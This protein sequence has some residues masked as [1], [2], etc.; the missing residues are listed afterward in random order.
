MELMSFQ[1]PDKNALDAYKHD[2][3]RPKLRLS[4]FLFLDLLGTTARDAADPAPLLKAMTDA[5]FWGNS[6]QSTPAAVARWFSDNLGLAYPIGDEQHPNIQ[7]ADSAMS[8]I[9]FSACMHQVA[10]FDHGFSSRGGISV[11]LF[12]ADEAMIYGPAL[13]RAVQLEKERAKYPRI[14]LDEAAVRVAKESLKKKIEPRQWARAYLMV[15]ADGVVFVNWLASVHS[16]PDETA[17]KLGEYRDQIAAL[18]AEHDGCTVVHDKY[19]W[20]AA[21]F[22]WFIKEHPGLDEDQRKTLLVD[23]ARPWPSKF[24]AFGKDIPAPKDG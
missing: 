16:H 13:N 3:D 20:L 4:A 14:V 23:Q 11:D 5:R 18:L 8:D 10:L 12:Y 21:Y 19:R 9:I 2:D 1:P 6:D 24:E 15:D 22:D 17:D 7:P